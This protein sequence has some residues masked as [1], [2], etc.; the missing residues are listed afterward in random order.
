MATHLTKSMP[1][2]LSVFSLSPSRALVQTASLPTH[3]PLLLAPISAPHIQ[4]G[5]LSITAWVRLACAISMKVHCNRTINYMEA[6]VPNEWYQR[7]Y[8]T[9]KTVIKHQQK[10]SWDLKESSWKMISWAEILPSISTAVYA[11]S[12]KIHEQGCDMC[13][14]SL[15]MRQFF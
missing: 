1:S 8:A 2:S 7:F 5:L 10:P 13:G 12:K 9:Q 11:C 14:F 15:Q 6:S 3:T 4:E